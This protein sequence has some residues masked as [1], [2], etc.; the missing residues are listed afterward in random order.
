MAGRPL[1]LTNVIDELDAVLFAWHPGTMGGAA[2]ADLLFGVESP[3]GKL[4]VTFPRAVGQI[5]T[6]Y[7]QK[8]GGKPP[9]PETA[10]LIDDIPARAPQTSIGNTSYHLD[11][12]YRP[13]F[14]FGHGLSYTT[15]EY[16]SL[17]LDRPVLR[18]GE[19]LTISV[20][21]TNTGGVVAD[22]VTQ[23]YVRDLVGNVT[24][25]VRELK[26]FQ[27][28]RLEPGETVTVSFRLGGDDL[29]FFG[30]DNTLVVEPGEFHLWVGGSSEAGLRAAFRLVDPDA[31]G[32][33]P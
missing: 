25:P 2:L 22:E 4:P 6:Y 30:R 32:V 19:T 1:V 21:L 10:V 8:H 23:L 17:Q 5:P 14:P 3:S 15:F 7:G 33:A 27:R 16:S 12:G 20:D 18:P 24:R 28:V 26:G 31:A 11:A 13:L 29:A 9:S